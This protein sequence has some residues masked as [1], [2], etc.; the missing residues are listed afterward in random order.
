MPKWLL[1]LLGCAPFL[2]EVQF[3][4]TFILPSYTIYI[5]CPPE[6]DDATARVVSGAQ[7]L[8]YGFNNGGGYVHFPVADIPGETLWLG[9][10]YAALVH[11]KEASQ[12][13]SYLVRLTSRTE[14]RRGASLRDVGLPKN[15]CKC[16]H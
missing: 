10:F 11:G 7:R 12:Q 15:Q 14:K 13:R 5:T 9:G 6:P 4:T 3:D 8:D 16:S 1:T 2:E